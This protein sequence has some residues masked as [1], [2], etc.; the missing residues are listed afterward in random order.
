HTTIGKSDDGLTNG[1]S[2]SLSF[3]ATVPIKKGC[4]P[5]Q[6]QVLFPCASSCSACFLPS[7]PG[8]PPSFPLPPRLHR[9]ALSSVRT[10]TSPRSS[11]SRCAAGLRDPCRNRFGDGR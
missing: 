11:R 3:I 10:R 9:R 7:P 5:G 1:L 2:P 8:R 4:L 6:F